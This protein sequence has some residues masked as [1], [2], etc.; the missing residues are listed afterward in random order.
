MRLL[1]LNITAGGRRQGMTLLELLAVVFIGS[2][3][4][5]MVFGVYTSSS[6]TLLRQE[7]TVEQLLNLRS[8]MALITRELRTAGNGYS[9]LGLGQ[10]DKVVVYR[11]NDDGTPLDWFYYP[12][13]PAD[14]PGAYPVYDVNQPYSN[15]ADQFK[16]DAITVCSLAPEFAAP[17]GY[18]SADYNPSTQT[19]SLSSPLEVPPDFLEADKD[20]IVKAGDAIALV[21]PGALTEGNYP[22]ILEVASDWSWTTYPVLSSI[23][24]APVPDRP[25]GMPFSYGEGSKVVNVKNLR[26]RTFKICYGREASCSATGED[27]GSGD[28]ARYPFLLMDTLD[29]RNQILADGIEDLQTGYYFGN[30]IGDATVSNVLD[31]TS[32]PVKRSELRA[33]RVVLVSRTQSP[34][35]LAKSNSY[36]RLDTAPLD[37]YDSAT[38]DRFPR[39]KIDSVTQLR[40]FNNNSVGGGG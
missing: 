23:K 12:G 33:I 15:T 17:L 8:S 29:S 11:R 4:L 9:L 40:N 38:R 35:S 5:S 31:V 30:D 21:P 7:Q 26:L 34:D 39:R 13:S 27:T 25:G 37:H 28:E 10:G 24:V 16:G 18:L 1:R 36:S 22:V 20:E 32:D 3:L 2:L 19:L 14:K 6:R